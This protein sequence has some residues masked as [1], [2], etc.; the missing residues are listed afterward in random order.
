MISDVLHETVWDLDDC[1]TKPT[2]DETY[3]GRLKQQIIKLRDEALYIARVLD[4]PGGKGVPPKAQA[5]AQ[6]AEER[7]QMPRDS[8]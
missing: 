8:A 4:T 6:I 5:L 7:R 1:L 2:F 3:K